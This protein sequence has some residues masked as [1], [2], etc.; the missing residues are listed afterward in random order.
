MDASVPQSVRFPSAGAASGSSRRERATTAVPPL[1]T[2]PGTPSFETRPPEAALPLAGLALCDWPE[3]P[4][5]T[6]AAGDSTADTA[7]QELDVKIVL[8][9]VASGLKATASFPAGRVVVLDADADALVE[10]WSAQ[11]LIAR[12]QLRSLD[13]HYCVQ[14]TELLDR[15]SRK[16]HP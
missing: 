10:I 5:E 13:G 14:V 4:S 3:L 16:S 7:G 2:H 11:Q 8:G 9:R 1:A 15:P 6:F 12:G